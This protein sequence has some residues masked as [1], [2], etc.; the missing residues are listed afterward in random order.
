MLKKLFSA[1]IDHPFI[2]SIMISDLFILIVHRPPFLFSIVMFSG[3]I[4][5]SMFLGQKLAL[6]KV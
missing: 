5:F 2:S 4:A 3:L 6:F 1:L